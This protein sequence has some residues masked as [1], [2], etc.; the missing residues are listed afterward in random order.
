M[1][2]MTVAASMVIVV[3]FQIKIDL[4]LNTVRCH[5]FCSETINFAP[6]DSWS[7]KHAYA[8]RFGEE[9]KYA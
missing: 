7:E 4:G 8:N 1:M 6:F 3:S 5:V 2:L 9:L